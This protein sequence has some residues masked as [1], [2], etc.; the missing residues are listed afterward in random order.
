MTKL[1]HPPTTTVG[2]IGASSMVG[3]CLLPLL[4]QA[5]YSVVAYSR[6]KVDLPHPEWRE[7]SASPASTDAIALWVCIAPIWVLPEHMDLIAAHGARRVIALSSTSRFTKDTSDDSKEQAVA[8][9]LATSEATLQHWAASRGIEW[10]VLRPTLIYGLGRD[11][12]I[13]EIA[14]IISRFGCFPLLGKADG[15]RQPI[16]AGDVAQAALGALQPSAAVNRAYN[17]SGGETL[18]YRDMVRRIFAALGRKPCLFSVPWFIFRMVVF[19][20]RLIP[21]Y[22]GWSPAM[23]S[24]M[25]KHL[26][27]EHTDA[28]HDLNFHP[29][30]FF[31]TAED[32]HSRKNR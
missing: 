20:L 5:G 19:A 9:R 10:V 22:R 1:S 29:R 12:N 28:T 31:P 32:V 25:N 11:K 21:R 27:F 26:V 18:S 3:E 4:T 17:L 14:R 30:A 16:H 6:H 15:L 7:L 13:T 2:V 23:V 8:A 24:R